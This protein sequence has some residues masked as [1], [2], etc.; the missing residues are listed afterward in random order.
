MNN[1]I[2]KKV[3]DY[4]LEKD[5]RI[6][7]FLLVI[8][9]IF[10]IVYFTGSFVWSND[11]FCYILGG[12]AVVDG[13]ILYRDF[14]D[15]KPPM[16]FFIYASLIKLFSYSNIL[17]SI[18]IAST[19]IQ[20]IESFLF[21]KI[22]E[23]I[24]D[25]KKAFLSSLIFITALSID[26]WNWVF[27]VFTIGLLPF[28]LFLYFLMINNPGLKHTRLFAAGIFLGLSVLVSTNYIVFL[29][30]L[31][32]SMIIT[33]DSFKNFVLKNISISAGF[34]FPIL[35]AGIYFY[36]NNA[37]YDWY[38]WNIKWAKMYSS[39]VSF[40][41]KIPN[42][43]KSL[44]LSYGWIPFYFLC[45]YGIFRFIK[46][47]NSIPKQ[48]YIFLFIILVI[49][50]VTRFFFGRPSSRYNP[51]ILPVIVIFI[52]FIDFSRVKKIFI[53]GSFVF[54]IIAFAVNNTYSFLKPIYEI[55]RN[56]TKEISRWIKENTPE[57]EKI[58]VWYEGYDFYLSSGRSMATGFFF[59]EQLLF[60]PPVHNNIKKEDLDFLWQKFLHQLRAEKPLYILDMSGN[61]GKFNESQRRG[62]LKEYMEQFIKYV[63]ENYYVANDFNG[64]IYKYDSNWK[65][66]DSIKAWKRKE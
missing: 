66:F 3:Y 50:L 33:K 27:N 38:W 24:F 32:L 25:R 19:I 17:V 39:E 36:Q 22:T 20:V 14:L 16:I 35:I 53:T 56:D 15:I 28:G 9:F 6:F 31:P 7:A 60:N 61:F 11:E 64:K 42:F 58:F 52:N 47:R 59:C 13:K 45:G 43:F 65:T 21:F 48:L 8:S 34:L 37:L 62:L 18:K 46:S 40:A 30:L 23:K 2:I 41:D 49:T 5:L 12:Q 4:I 63:N 51:Y 1:I 55:R 10:K 26:K 57:N 44:V 54:L 29:A